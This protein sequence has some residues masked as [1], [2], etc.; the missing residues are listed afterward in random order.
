MLP[1]GLETWDPTPYIA[2]ALPI[3]LGVFGVALMRELGMRLA[4]GIKGVK[5][6]PAFFIPN[7]QIGMCLMGVLMVAP[8]KRLLVHDANLCILCACLCMV[9]IR[10]LREF[11]QQQPA[12]KLSPQPHR[13]L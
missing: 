2:T 1:P 3:S 4:A 6:G 11:W 8:E 10:T 5:L 12:Q 13:P 7:G 9:V